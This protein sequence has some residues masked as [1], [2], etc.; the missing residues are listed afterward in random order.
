MLMLK[1]V[2]F[3]PTSAIVFQ[4]LEFCNFLIGFEIHQEQFQISQDIQRPKSRMHCIEYMK[5]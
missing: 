5:A 1:V 2:V 4:I 3:G